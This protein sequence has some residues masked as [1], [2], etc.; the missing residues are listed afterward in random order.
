VR[1]VVQDTMVVKME[2]RREEERKKM[3]RNGNN[4]VSYFWSVQARSLKHVHA[5]LSSVS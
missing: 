4:S 5:G 2:G 3:N 1:E